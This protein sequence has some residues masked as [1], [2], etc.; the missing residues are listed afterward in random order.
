MGSRRV[1]G[2]FAEFAVV[3]FSLCG[4]CAVL[5]DLCEKFCGPRWNNLKDEAKQKN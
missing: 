4:L 5:G 2:V 1:R 3:L